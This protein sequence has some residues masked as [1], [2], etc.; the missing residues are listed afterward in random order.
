MNFFDIFIIY[1]ACGAPFGVYNWV[2]KRNEKNRVFIKS[3]LISLFWFP[4]AFGL[5]QKYVTKQLPNPILSKKEIFRDEEILET[6]KQLED[7][8]IKNKFD[9]SIFELREIF[10]RYIGLLETAQ[11][12]HDS[13]ETNSEFFEIAG[14]KNPA[15]A[16]KCYQRRNR[17]LLFFHQT[18]AGQDFLKMISEFV[19]RFP[20]DQEIENISLKLIRLLNDEMTE[21]NL[22]LLFNNKKQSRAK[23][24]VQEPEKE[25]WINDRQPPQTANALRISVNPAGATAPN[26]F[27]KD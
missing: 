10:D 22:K 21:K 11:N 12:Q 14:S 17:K 15:L 1:L 19:F 23:T 7:I 26:S 16:S 18:L 2:T 4:F 3:L 5:L 6:K 20:T 24:S 25:L 9:I 8:F 27:I 13:L